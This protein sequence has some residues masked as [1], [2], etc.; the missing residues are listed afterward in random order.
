MSRRIKY[1]SNAECKAYL[2][3]ELQILEGFYPMAMIFTFNNP[4]PFGPKRNLYTGNYWI[5]EIGSIN[6][7]FVVS[8][9]KD[10]SG[11]SKKVLK[12]NKKIGNEGQIKRDRMLQLSQISLDSTNLKF[13]IRFLKKT[14]REGKKYVVESILR[15]VKIN[16]FIEN[17]FDGKSFIECDVEEKNAE[18]INFLFDK[19]PMLSDFLSIMPANF[20]SCE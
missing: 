20:F 12:D 13:F 17:K 10:S 6:F 9:E 8:N 4:L 15:N 16:S 14:M 11:R 3:I 19:N 5:Q 2:L 18:I 1:L 7:D